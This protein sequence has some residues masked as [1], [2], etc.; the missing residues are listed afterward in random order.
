MEEILARYLDGELTDSEAA[1]FLRLTERD[2]EIERALR[3]YETILESAEKLPRP[4]T[5]PRF[6]NRVMAAVAETESNSSGS[7]T[8]SARWHWSAV[9]ATL[10]IGLGL[11][12]LGG[13]SHVPSES[14]LPDAR[15]AGVVLP[16]SFAAPDPGVEYLGAVQLVYTASSPEVGRVSVAGSFNGWDP[17]AAPMTRDGATWKILLVLPAGTHEYMLIE[18]GDRWITDPGAPGIRRDGFGG[19]NGVLNVSS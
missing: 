6:S 5:S 18:D 17:V 3:D 16:A 1:E 9:A 4:M 12:F 19:S 10:V 2:P 8:R 11:G 7:R 15:P 14:V 13:R